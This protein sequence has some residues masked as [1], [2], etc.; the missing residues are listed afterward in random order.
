M[1]QCDPIGD[2]AICT[3]TKEIPKSSDSIGWEQTNGIGFGP[4][5]FTPGPRCKVWENEVALMWQSLSPPNLNSPHL[6]KYS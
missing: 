2:H 3:K 4:K 5:D 1:H 6:R